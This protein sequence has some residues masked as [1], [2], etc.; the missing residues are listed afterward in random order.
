MVNIQ[1]LLNSDLINLPKILSMRIKSNKYRAWKIVLLF[2]L[3]ASCEAKDT[4]VAQQSLDSLKLKTGDVVLCGSGTTKLGSVAFFT[5]CPEKSKPDFEL[6]MALLHSFEYDEAEKVFAKII[7]DEPGCAMAYWGVAMSNFHP[8]WTP[9]TLEELQKGSKAIKI[10]KGIDNKSKRESEYINAISHLFTD[11]ERVDHHTRCLNFEKEMENLY[12]NYPEDKEAAI[13]YALALN[14]AADPADKSFSRQRKAGSILSGLYPNEPDHPGVVHYIIHTYDS[15]ELAELALP[16]ARK[17]ASVAP[18][19]AHALHMPSHIFTR[20]G[21]WE[22]G[23]NSNLASVTSAKCY[24]EATGMKGHWDEELH[25]LDYLVYSYLQRGENELAK[26][27]IEYLDSIQVVTPLSFKVAYSF[28][29]MPARYVLENK[30]WPEASKLTSRHVSFPWSRFPWQ[31]AII[32]FTRLLGSVHTGELDSARLELRELNRLYDT[33]VEQKN[34][35]QATQVKIQAT[36]GEAWLRLAEGNKNKALELMYLAA[37]MEDKTGKHPVTPGEVVPARELVADMLMEMNEPAKALEEYEAD[38]KKHP[39]RF[40][41]LHGAATAASKSGNIEKAK[42]YYAQ[43]IA[44]ANSPYAIRS[45][46]RGAK[47]FVRN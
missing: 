12:K 2:S 21:L 36:S 14:A 38:L 19:S 17:Y 23:I 34:Q 44:V 25:G 26:R 9:P 27:Q 6:A 29:A 3:L 30:S 16:A 40:N 1:S 42:H 8:L 20:L 41:A 10:A 47:S 4:T 5:S 35:Y 24:A 39:N 45:E 32:H 28:A 31:R 37:E 7:R 33:L 11:W 46:I 18:S 22:E 13:L 43:L 15:P